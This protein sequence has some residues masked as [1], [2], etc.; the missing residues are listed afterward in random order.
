MCRAVGAA[1]AHTQMYVQ[2]GQIEE[3]IACLRLVLEQAPDNQETLVLLG[4]SNLYIV[5]D[6][7][8]VH[9]Y[10]SVCNEPTVQQHGAAH[11]LSHST[12]S[13]ICHLLLLL[14]LLLLLDY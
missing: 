12:G 10:L 6:D 4:V 13:C 1:A 8:R 9:S 11:R 5:T 7:T 3:A 14:L 2:D